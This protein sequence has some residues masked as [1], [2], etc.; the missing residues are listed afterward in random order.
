MHEEQFLSV[1]GNQTAGQI[2]SRVQAGA[3]QHPGRHELRVQHLHLKAG[4]GT[5]G[6]FLSK[7]LI[8]VLILDEDIVIFNT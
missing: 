6:I 7:Q 5:S 3:W 1:D 4:S 8:L 2:G